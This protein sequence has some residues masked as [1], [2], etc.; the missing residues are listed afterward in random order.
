MPWKETCP[1]DER[2][3]FISDWLKRDWTMSDLCAH[4]DISRKT[5]YKWLD[6]FKEGGA[7]RSTR[8]LE[9]AAWR[10]MTYGQLISKAGLRPAT[11]HG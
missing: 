11:A 4:Y 2:Q 6:R 1:M 5:G 7:R 10:P 8:D 9:R 3:R